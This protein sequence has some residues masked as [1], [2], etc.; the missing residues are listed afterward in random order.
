M[1][2]IIYIYFFLAGV[3]RIHIMN[4]LHIAKYYYISLVEEKEVGRGREGDREAR[5]DE[6]VQR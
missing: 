6:K 4:A 2:K 5:S 3:H 1:T